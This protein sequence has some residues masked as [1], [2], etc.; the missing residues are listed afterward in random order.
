[1][2]QVLS[3][4]ANPTGTTPLALDE[5]IRAIDAR[6]RGA[7][8]RDRL[9]LTSQ[10][11]PRLDDLSGHLLRR[12][13]Q[14]VHFSAHGAPA[15]EIRLLS[16]AGSPTPVPPEALAR[17]FRVLKDDVRVVL[18]S[19]CYSEKQARAIVE[20]VDCAVGMT[21]A[22]GDD[23]A[24]AFASTFYAALAY[25]R[26]VRYAFDLGVVRLTGEGVADASGLVKLH[27]RPGLN[28]S[29]VVL[30]DPRV[31]DR[32]RPKTGSAVAADPT[33][34][35]IC[36]SQT[37]HEF[38]ADLMALLTP[39]EQAGMI[40]VWCDDTRIKTDQQWH[41]EVKRAL[42]SARV[43]V[44]LVSDDLLASDFFAKKELPWLL[45]AE[46]DRGL[47]VL[48]V[49]VRPSRF[50]QASSLAR[51]QPA[52]VRASPLA[53]MSQPEQDRVWARLV[54]DIEH[55][56]A[57]REGSVGALQQEGKG[58]TQPVE[59]RSATSVETG[60]L[61]D[62]AGH[63]ARPDPAFDLTSLNSR[64]FNWKTALSMALASD[65]VYQRPEAVA[66]VVKRNWGLTSCSTFDV[67]DTQCFV[68]HTDSAILV[69]FRGTESLNDW[70]SNLDTWP[71]SKSYGT[72]HRGF[73]K[74]F[75][76]VR[77]QL[78]GA[79]KALGPAQKVIH[80]TGHSLG[81]ALATIAACELQGL[82]PI[83]GVYTFGQPRVGD[84]T[85]AA[86]IKDHYPTG[87]HRF[88]F[89][90]DIVPR[91]PPGYHHLGRLYHFDA[92]GFLQRSTDESGAGST[93]PPPLTPEEFENLKQTARA[94]EVASHATAPGIGEAQEELA[95]RSLEGILP[96][97]RDHRMSRYLF[98][99]R[100]QIPRGSFGPHT[101]T[102]I[103]EVLDAFH[104]QQAA[105]PKGELEA[106]RRYP[107][108]VRVRNLAWSPPQGV[109]VNS[110][111]GPIYSLLATREAI[112]RMHADPGVFSLSLSRDLDLPS[113][114]ECAVSIPFVHADAIH[115]G[116]L[117]EKGDSAVVGVI[118]L[119]IDILHE[120][121]LDDEGDSRIEA[122]WVQRDTS[123]PTP[124][125]VHPNLYTQDYGTLYTKERIQAF[126]NNDLI[127][128]NRTTPSSLRDP[129]P[130]A[131][132]DYGH[133]TH[134]ASIAA[135]R[136]V[137]TFAGGMAPEAR[138]A[139]VVPH[140]KTSPGSPPSMGYSNSH[141]DALAFLMA[142][143]KARGL[144]IAVNVSLGMNAGA[145]DGTSDLEKVFDAITQN[146]KAEGFVVVKSAGNE[147]GH[148]GH[149]QIQAA[150]G[151]CILVQ[152]D[153]SSVL[154]ESDYLEFWYH[155]HDELEFTVID[156]AGNRSPTVRN[157]S[158]NASY[159]SAGNDIHLKLTP[160][161]P[162]ND[163][164]RLVIQT[165][166][167]AAPIQPGTWTLEVVAVSLG[168][169]NGRLDAW[170]ERDD[171]RPVSFMQ[172]T[173]DT[174][175]SIPGTAETVVCV[176]ANN[177]ATPLMLTPSSS[178][179]PT[180]RNG[181]KPDLNAPGDRITAARSNSL[182][183]QAVVTLNGTSM[184]APHVTGAMALVL[185]AR[186]KKSL[187]DGTKR[188]FNA[189]NLAGMVTR[190]SKYFNKLHNKAT[191]YGAL[192]ALSFFREADL[193]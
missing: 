151:V 95:D 53:T 39:L 68:V 136:A 74:A 176:S 116:N 107:V 24:I 89:D 6:I 15:G 16:A 92:N 149:V 127:N 37:D 135:G 99:I 188:Q 128:H 105:T 67:H 91:V 41:K 156:P 185:S 130:S 33:G 8:H 165:I 172:G 21:P 77:T 64:H 101:E 152:W 139:V 131:A 55:A 27:M 169:E 102:E 14:I 167:V 2:L 60:S 36:Y 133:G 153:S 52:I 120:A 26:S 57:G 87:F 62:R 143:H 45:A 103:D 193:A 70:L 121:F 191:G 129:G 160:H 63:G 88:V 112:G 168:R 124:R 84:R 40:E 140:M 146:G 104:F 166:P 75:D 108:Q 118:D 23:H 29:D 96:S 162:D 79:I 5:E 122:V 34:V 125:Q 190:S 113:V 50:A 186:H 138:I 117:N 30:L 145:H 184:A 100:N 72:V 48:P 111:V 170:V 183:H 164:N 73:V 110:Q 9:E 134:V 59:P 80:L 20:H 115:S 93:E 61:N 31:E 83:T 25:G 180:R 157:A 51:F 174:T 126:V 137:G 97:V 192:D 65:L 98:A 94:I 189:I 3:L 82:F 175:L 109:V 155:S 17:L 85:T 32:P 114:Q 173:D 35:F 49:I 159:S 148:R 4:T 10:W 18:L 56:L 158:R 187:S 150:V 119:G 123:G 132:V 71:T 43:A 19:A 78:I 42:D 147:R 144:P 54:H 178:Y 141:Q 163:D 142:F 171:S 46:Q 90:D 28:P 44:L 179:G 81:G 13:P 58:P 182:D 106:V 76:Q 177:A 181:P 154:R 11:T 1:M 69:A 66:S 86:F 7:E 38:L 22:I 12:K 161:V 47:V